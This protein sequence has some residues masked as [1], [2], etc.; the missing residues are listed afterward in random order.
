MRLGRQITG[1]VALVSYLFMGAM[2][3]LTV[4]PGA[5]GHWP[6]DFHLTGYDAQSI[7]PFAEAI[8]EKAKTAYGVILS[9]LDRVFIVALALWMA[10]L[11]WRG[12]WVRYF[13]VG[14]AAIYAVIDLAENAAIYRFMFVDVMDA[15]VIKTAHHLTMAKFASLYLCVLVLIVHLRRTV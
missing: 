15:L 12:G 4:L 1:V 5:D 10:L 3:Y 13:V 7:A 8:S 2:M 6:P 9:R 14:F 11:G